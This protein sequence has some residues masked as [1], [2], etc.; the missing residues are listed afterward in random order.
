MGT[1]ISSFSNDIIIRK[2]FNGKTLDQIVI[3]TGLSKGTV[4]N[5]IKRWKDKLGSTGIEEIREFSSIVSKSGLTIPEC[6]EGFR[7]IKILKELGIGDEYED[8][9]DS[10]PVKNLL[11]EISN[12]TID[13]NRG[14]NSYDPFRF[15]NHGLAK[16]KRRNNNT[17]TKN[18]FHLFIEDLY[19]TCKKHAIKPSDFIGFIKDLHDFY[20]FIESGF[21]SA[22]NNDHDL[23]LS[24]DK[25]DE[26]ENIIYFRRA[27]SREFENDIQQNLIKSDMPMKQ[28]HELE[29]YIEI[30]FISQVSYYII[31]I[32]DECKEL[33]Q[34]RKSLHSEIS[35]LENKKSTLEK[36]IRK[37]T[38]KNTNILSRLQWYDFL[39]QDLVDRY[40]LNLDEEIILFS[41]IINDFKTFKY[42]IYDITKEYKQIQS[43]RKERDK[44][45]AEINLKD[46]LLQS[47]LQQVDLQNSQLLVSRQTMKTYVELSMLG[48]DLKRL[49]QLHGMI[50]EIFLANNMSVWN[51]VTKFIDEIE[52]QYDNKLGFETKIKELKTTLDHLKDEITQYKPNLQNQ[53]QLTA[54]LLYLKNNGVTDEDIISMSKLIASLQHSKTLT[55]ALSQGQNTVNGFK[56]NITEK[57]SK[58]ITWD[59]FGNMLRSSPDIYSEI[60]KLT[61]PHNDTELSNNLDQI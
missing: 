46:P 22:N 16:R 47:L 36:D 8:G 10:T 17:K 44:I 40:N 41:S 5:M 28:T 2:Y 19:I 15:P 9:E 53:N 1:R 39:K 21:R 49:K 27:S 51:P 20:P 32:R 54:S 11:E 3:D 23:S 56:N 18:D 45:Q 37:L 4:Y 58:I 38:E 55:N 30:P 59:L 26:S 14:N 61:I 35:T 25:D 29:G 12:E 43:L 13:W 6:A 50:I 7:I 31:Q 34:Y 33:E 57:N 48:F 52:S 24:D 60:E 42:N